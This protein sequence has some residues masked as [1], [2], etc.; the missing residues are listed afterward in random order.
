MK[1]KFASRAAKK[2]ASGIVR[3]KNTNGTPRTQAATTTVA[4]QRATREH[5]SR[6]RE[7]LDRL[8]AVR[9]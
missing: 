2:A 5:I 8:D 3:E 7:A 4:R 9:F 6:A 1:S